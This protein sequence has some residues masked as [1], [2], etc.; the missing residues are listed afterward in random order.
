MPKKLTF[1]VK[2][3]TQE[4]ERERERERETY[5]HMEEQADRLAY[6]RSQSQYFFKHCPGGIL[7]PCFVSSPNMCA[8]DDKYRC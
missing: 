7:N 5:E 1:K 2:D 8:L 4:R 3:V 6:T